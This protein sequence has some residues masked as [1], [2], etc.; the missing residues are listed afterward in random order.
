L[1]TLAQVYG[2]ALSDLLAR[3]PTPEPVETGPDAATMKAAQRLGVLPEE[4]DAAARELW[5]RGLS[6]ERDARLGTA[7]RSRAD[8]SRRGHVT[9]HLIEELQQVVHASA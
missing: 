4:A 3:L 9:R 8:Q 6:A 1:A 7:T 2:V 5:G